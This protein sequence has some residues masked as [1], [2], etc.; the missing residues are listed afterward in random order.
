LVA[1]PTVVVVAAAAV[2]ITLVATHSSSSHGQISSS[3]QPVPAAVFQVQRLNRHDAVPFNRRLSFAVRHGALTDVV[4]NAPTGQQIDGSFNRT[5][6]RWR[7]SS[8]FMPLTRLRAK[9]SYSDLAHHVTTKTVRLRT[10]DNKL[11]LNALLSP[12][13]GDTVGVGSPVV[14]TF[15][16]DVPTDMRAAVE[17]R[18]S[19]TSQ[20]AVVGAWHWMSS[21]EVH[22]RPPSYWKSGT[23][24]TV[25]SNL[26]GLNFGHGVWG[27]A[28]THHTSFKIGASHISEVDIG[29][30]VMRVYDDGRLIKTFPVSTGRDQ[31]PTMDGVHIAIEKSSVVQMDSATVG[32]PKGSPGYYNETVYWDV[33]IS[34]GGE[35]VHAAPWSV[36][37]QGHVNVSHGCVNLSTANA[38]WFYNWALRGDVVDVYDGVRPPSATDPGT[39]DWNMS[40]KDWVAGG[41]APS[42]AAQSIHPP[43]AHDT[44]PGFAPIHSSHH[45]HAKSHAKTSSKKHKK[46]GSY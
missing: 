13:G 8:S 46:S 30:H 37:Q 3:S 26:E 6:S 18:L 9:V 7:S 5:H 27:A 4:V 39:A 1:V 10:S 25:S 15:D 34:D 42:I 20:P 21:R 38:E 23:K 40:W 28:G 12:G 22:W 16:R 36:G 44:E 19:V 43:M 11:H 31:Y 41:A 17:S 45:H 35:F 2:G 33:R 24:V 32:I 14:V 29:G